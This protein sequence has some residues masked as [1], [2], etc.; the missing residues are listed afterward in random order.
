MFSPR[1]LCIQGKQMVPHH[2]DTSLHRFPVATVRILS[3]RF[4][5]SLNNF[6]QIYTVYCTYTIA[7]IRV[8][9]HKTYAYI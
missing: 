1:F 4:N 9:A 2:I 7:Y 6:Y 8:Y 3:F 5:R